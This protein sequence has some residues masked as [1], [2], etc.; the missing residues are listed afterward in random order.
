MI[1][2]DSRRLVQKQGSKGL[3]ANKVRNNE[4]EKG[5]VLCGTLGDNPSIVFTLNY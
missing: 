2:P 4:S 3:H 1:C 5:G